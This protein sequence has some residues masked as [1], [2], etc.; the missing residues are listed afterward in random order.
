MKPQ[1]EKIL[2]HMLKGRPITQQGAA[3]IYGIW[4]LSA[5]IHDLRW[6]HGYPIT[7][8]MLP[9]RIPDT[10]HHAQYRLDKERP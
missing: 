9:N 2:K 5:I 7:T 10:G 4:R 1:T 8:H 3:Q 6:N